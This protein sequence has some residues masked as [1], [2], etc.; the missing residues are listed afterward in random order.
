MPLPAALLAKLARRGIV[1]KGEGSVKYLKIKY[2][3]KNPTES[4][5]EEKEE[6]IAEDYDAEEEPSQ[7][8]YDEPVRKRKA[9]PWTE[10]I[11]RRLT[12]GQL[13]GYKS[14][15]NKYNIFHKCTLYCVTFWNGKEKQPSSEYFL[16]KERLL[17]RHPL[18]KNWVEV[19][20]SGWYA[21]GSEFPNNP[22]LIAIHLP[23]S[24]AHY[25]WNTVDDVVSWLPPG[26]PDSK[27]SK[28]AATIRRE[29]DEDVVDEIPEEMPHSL[30]GGA[31]VLA[32]LPLPPPSAMPFVPPVPPPAIKRQRNR[33]LDKVIRSKHERP[34]R[35]KPPANVDV[36]DP[37]DPAAY[38][39]I[40]RGKWSAG[41]EQENKKGGVD[42]TVSGSGFQQRPYPSPGAIL[43]ANR[44][45]KG[46]DDEDND[47]NDSDDEGEK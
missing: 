11:K 21:S 37:M 36:L 12:E 32:N 3:S 14:C 28:S 22:F 47:F 46:S 26:H 2:L 35:Y 29:L 23:C 18:P 1:D 16:R 4:V 8:D 34:G 31:G 39:D 44:K 33:D 9:N 30:G 24:A 20:D 38:S 43:Q 6:I 10:N 5:P 19:F 40:P 25:Y 13:S 27:V 15:P 45:H 17:K 41:L 42:S 7:Y